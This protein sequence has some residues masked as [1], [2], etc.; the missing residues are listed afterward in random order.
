M[1]SQAGRLKKLI[2]ANEVLASIESLMDLLP[3]LLRLAQDVTGAEASSILLYDK[4]KDVLTF[5]LA[6]ND[7]VGE[8]KMRHLKYGFELPMG[9][10]IAGW[11]AENRKPLNVTDAQ[12]DERF[13]KAADERTGFKTRC[14]LCIP[15]IHKDQ[16]LGV[17]QVLN[18]IAKECFEDEDR[19]LLESFGHLAGVALVRSELMLQRLDQQK[20]ETQ[21]EAAS[22]IQKQFSPK[23]PEF[24]DGNIVWGSSV[25]AQF[26]GGDLYDFISN[27]D[28]SW[29]IYVADVSGKG[30]PAA[31][32]MS[33]LWTRIRA[34][35]LREKSPGEMLKAVN[36]GAWEFMNGELF[37]TMVLL[38]YD[39]S[40][41]ECEYAVA[42]HPAPLIVD[43]GVV[44]E[45]ERPFGL[46][47]GIMDE[48]E[49]GTT[50]FT[51]EKGQSLIIVTDGVDEARAGN[52]EFF[53]E[54]RL[55]ETLKNAGH[56]PLGEKL[57]TAVARWRG[58]TP[59]NDDTTVVEIYR[60]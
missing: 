40:S 23:Q 55:V 43:N 30:L 19:E 32:I 5:S 59:S 47:V 20:L 26:V 10:G 49:F 21:L 24:D 3:Q 51:I 56:P 44:T 41:G 34:E 45:L 25:P 28:G 39:P 8:D 14:I 42:G 4:E 35:A 50:K 53:G 31:L 18:S 9:Q 13:S 17:V 29:Y 16:L 22:R 6:M 2:Q 12:N 7:V 48:G 52:G 37:A 36:A 1:S 54:K 58:E 11:V 27:S 57:L 15:I 38:R 46:P 60:P 33:A